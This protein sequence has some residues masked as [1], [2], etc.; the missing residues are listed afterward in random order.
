MKVQALS[1]KYGKRLLIVI[2]NVEKNDDEYLEKLGSLS[3][4]VLVTSRRRDLKGI[5]NTFLLKPL[6]MEY[7]RKHILC[8]L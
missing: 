8:T 7:C 1:D 2:D 3:S 6:S 5:N 4:L